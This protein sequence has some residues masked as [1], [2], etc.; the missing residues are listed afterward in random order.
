[1][2]DQFPKV[3]SSTSTSDN[4]NLTFD[5]IGIEQLDEVVEFL[6]KYFFPT[7]PIG[8][9]VNMDVEVEVRPWVHRFISSVLR[10]GHSLAV[11]DASARNQLAAVSL[12]QLEVQ[13]AVDIGP[14]LMDCVDPEKHPLMLM[15]V[16]F[17]EE[18]AGDVDFFHR[19]GVER[20]VDITMLAVNTAYAS[21]G[22]ATQLIQLTVS[23]ARCQ[24]DVSVFKTEAV[25]E[26][27]ARAHFKA[28]F[29]TIHQIHYDD[30][31]YEGD[32]PLAGLVE[33]DHK[34]GRLMV[35]NL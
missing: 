12:S 29:Q 32:K 28:G 23:R 3:T 35:L 10:Q 15:N 26:Y 16:Y 34:T 8:N 4:D 31:V 7:V 20:V 1:M 24:L 19:Y 22:L 25:S 9:I 18:L 13:S 21:R 17:L 30:F 33:T 5:T 2:L 11:R 14:S 27:A 6:M